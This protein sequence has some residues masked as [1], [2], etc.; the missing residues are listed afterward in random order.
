[1][2]KYK[3]IS[4]ENPVSTQPSMHKQSDQE[5][6]DFVIRLIAHRKIY[7]CLLIDNTLIMTERVK[8][9]LAVVRP[10]AALTKT[11]EAHLTCRQVNH[12]IIDTAAAKAA[13]CHHTI[14][15]GLALR[16]HLQSERMLSAIDLADHR[17]Q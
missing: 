13:I 5:I 2:H 15:I 9:G 3:S 14:G 10:H 1:M 7:P 11:A 4:F 17:I 12:R 6:K 16:K 8:T